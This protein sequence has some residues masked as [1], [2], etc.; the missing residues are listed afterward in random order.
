MKKP[1]KKFYEFKNEADTSYGLYIYG[2]LT[3]NKEED[4]SATESDVDLNDF[5]KALNQLPNDSTL[6]MYVNSPGGSV[7]ASS[8][9]ASM[10]QR[11]K[12]TKGIHITSYIDGLCA[13]ATSFL[14]MVSDEIRLYK[15]SMLMVHKPMSIAFGNAD[16]MRKEIETLDSIEENVMMP[17]YMKKAKVDEATIKNLIDVESWLSAEETAKYF[18]VELLG[19]NKECTACADLELLK[20]YKNVPKEL[21]EEAEAEEKE[22]EKIIPEEGESAPGEEKTEP[23][24]PETSPNEPTKEEEEPKS[25][26]NE[27]NESEKEEKEGN[28]PEKEEKAPKSPEISPE[29]EE[30]E[31]KEEPK[32]HE[33]VENTQRIDYSYFENKLNSLKGE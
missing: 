31:E 3:D 15:N 26:K 23:E 28:T 17:L 19:T 13:S 25:T 24:P 2:A 10:L 16:D 8:T 14:I 1:M 18:D 21:K 33:D 7:F 5:K 30:E 22:L 4:W 20:R 11:A 6:N 12:E 27:P 9:M 32:Q 29:E